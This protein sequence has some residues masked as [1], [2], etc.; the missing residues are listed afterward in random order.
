MRVFEP[1]NP[2][3]SERLQWYI[4]HLP[5]LVA[6]YPLNEVAGTVAKNKAPATFGTLDGTTTGATIG[7]PGKAGRAY[8]FDGTNDKVTFPEVEFTSTSKLS[9][10]VLLNPSSVAGNH[11][12]M[13]KRTGANSTFQFRIGET[14]GDKKLL[15]SWQHNAGSNENYFG[16]NPTIDAGAWVLVGVSFDWASPGSVDIFK[17][18]VKTTLARSAGTGTTPLDTN[19]GITIGTTNDDALDYAGTMQHV[20]RLSRTITEAEHLRL[21]R[22]AGLA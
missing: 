15:F 18:G 20:A 21:A 11:M 1:L 12:I 19:V 17:N 13:T 6:Y 14:A 8:S 10:I 5:N 7:Q 9:I 16:A 3:R 2:I 4:K 22:I